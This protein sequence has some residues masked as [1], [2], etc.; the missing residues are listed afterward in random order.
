MNMAKDNWDSIPT[1]AKVFAKQ[2][3]GGMGLLGGMTA[4]ASLANYLGYDVGPGDVNSAMPEKN[5]Q[6]NNYQ[7]KEQGLMPPIEP[8]KT[9]QKL[10]IADTTGIFGSDQPYIEAIKYLQSKGVI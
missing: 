7:M 8:E 2:I 3:P 5:T 4:L 10:G 6:K 9:K 1:A